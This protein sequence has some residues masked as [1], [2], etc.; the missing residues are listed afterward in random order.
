MLANGAGHIYP[1]SNPSNAGTKHL[2]VTRRASRLIKK[3]AFFAVRGLFVGREEEVEQ[4]TEAIRRAPLLWVSGESGSGK[5]TLL[6]LGLV[7]KLKQTR[8]FLP[9]Y[10]D[11]WG[12][13]WE[14]GPVASLTQAL[15]ESIEPYGATLRI[16][17][18]PN[19]P[20]L[21]RYLEQ[22][23]SV[24]NLTP[25]VILD[26]FDD[27]IVD[28][29]NRFRPARGGLIITADELHQQNGFWGEIA[30]L[31]KAEMIRC[32]VVVRQEQSWGQATISFVTVR[33][34]VV[35]R[36]RRRYVDQILQQLSAGAVDSPER[37]WNALQQ[38]L[39]KDLSSKG[40]LPI[41]MRVVLLQL[42][43]LKS[44]TPKA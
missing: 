25:L 6:Q 12:N 10:I 4:L 39:E 17:A 13:D 14:A 11:N 28:N 40:G 8:E 44:L 34:F 32:I 33:E 5:S 27:Y 9:L 37:G 31:L 41:Q 35:S 19:A 23:S 38:Q 29:L 24:L 30:R 15:R 42:S 16:A 21:G 1:R 18:R 26:Q 2:L 7:P 22:V 20:D 43:T 36:M 3:D